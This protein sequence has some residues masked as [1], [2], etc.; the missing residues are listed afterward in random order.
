[1]VAIET[2]RDHSLALKNDGTVVAWGRNQ[3]GQLGDG[4]VEDRTSP[5]QVLEDVRLICGA[6]YH[7]LAMKPDGTG[8]KTIR[9]VGVP[10]RWQFSRLWVTWW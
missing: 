3:Y 10:P 8:V 4:T 1:M 9:Q 2:G 6:A 5:L 7:S